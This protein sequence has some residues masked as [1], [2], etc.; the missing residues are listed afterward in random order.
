MAVYDMGNHSLYVWVKNVSQQII[1]T[2]PD[3]FTLT[4]NSKNTIACRIDDSLNRVLEPGSLS[5]GEIAFDPDSIPQELIFQN[6]EAGKV[7][8]IFQ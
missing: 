1:T 6:R 2:H 5:H 3:Y 4:D 8:K 7:S